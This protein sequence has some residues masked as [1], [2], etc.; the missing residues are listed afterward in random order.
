MT[1]V[2][3]II[4]KVCTA[5]A[6]DSFITQRE[7]DGSYKVIESRRSKI[8]RVRHWRGAMAYWGLAQF[9]ARRWATLKWLNDRARKAA[10]FSSPEEFA[11]SLAMD[12]TREISLLNLGSPTAGGIGIHFTAYERINGYWIP[13]LFLISN[14]LDASYRSLRPEGMG[15][16]RETFHGV[17]GEP[18]DERHREPNYRLKVHAFLHEGNI[19]GFNNGDPVLYNPAANALFS[20]F[21]EF[22]VRGKLAG[23]DE[24]RTWTALARRPVEI[25][26]KAQRDFCPRGQRLVGGKPHDLAITQNGEYSSDTG[27]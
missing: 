23:R 2:S 22:G 7:I 13:E 24:V 3:A 11:K 16:T 5:H 6:S 15:L 27:D 9:N 8:I 1:V 10:R 18:P 17:S 19:I 25:V 4:S 14:W 26:C 21:Q 12:L 20:M